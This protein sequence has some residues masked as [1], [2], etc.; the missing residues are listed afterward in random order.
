MS[1]NSSSNKQYTADSIEVL[2]GLDPVKKRPGMYTETTRPNHLAQEV[3]DNSVDEALAGHATKIEVV[4]HEDGSLSVSDNGRGMPV[5]I[6]SEEGVPGVEL[7]L[8]RLHAGGK[9][10]ND[11]YSFSGGLH[12]VGVSVVNALS[13]KLE[14]FIRR[15][16]NLHKI[17]FADG[18]KTHDLEVIDTVGKRN[19]GTL[20][21]FWP[22]AKYFES[23]KFSISR[24]RHVLRAK[25]VLC[26]GLHMVFNN[27]QTNEK[28]EWHFEDGLKDYLI[29]ATDGFETCPKVP[30]TGS[31]AGNSEAVDWAIQWL[32]EGGDITQESYVNL[33]PTAQ[34]GTHVNGFRTGCLE[35]MREFCEFRNLLPRGLKLGPEDIWDKSCFVL[36]AKLADPQFSGQ[37]K[38]RLSSR[39]AAAFISGVVKDAF[40]LWLNQHTDEAEQLATLC[41]NNAQKRMRASKKVV[42]KKVTSG[43][44][45][46]GKLADCSGVDAMRSELFLVEGDSAGGSAKQARDREYQAIMPLRG[47]IL[48]TWEVES[49][50]I[51]ASQEVH[52]I[53]VAIGVDPGS[54]N[55]EGLR[56]GKVCILADADSDGL[57]IAT[58]LCALF[59]KH[60]QPLVEAG[61]IY[62]AMPPLY[63]IDVG[64]EVFYALDESE[65][66]GVLDRI[67]A[68]KKRGKVN[69]QRFKGLGE[70][71]PMQLRE[72]TMARDT[73]RLVQLTI[74][75]H[76]GTVANM[77]MLLGKKRAADRK[78]WLE[79]KGDM[80]E[81]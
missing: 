65:R 15:S 26:P 23:V 33:I 9:F 76:P 36:S 63:R 38:E 67:E 7:I 48:N 12:G 32:T 21:H 10:S 71:N 79:S 60:F 8:T 27:K 50:E 11:N 58:L 80:A 1:E 42:R 35:A 31:M 20:V 44:A 73:R 70:M 77:D 16:G 81:V 6:H 39:E 45:L 78:A 66:K 47:K 5:D 53:S 68:E 74:E 72:T 13:T 61:H 25:A 37:T 28:D 55:L 2:S 59:V 18:D 41:I 17:A 34:G 62:V 54:D 30:F 51:L 69:V 22:D 49:S 56:Y 24:L 64:K 75:D 52:D 4:L 43:P 29:G 46:P 57:H 40:S 3:I 14:V 19:T